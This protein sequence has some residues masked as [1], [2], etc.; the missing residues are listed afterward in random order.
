M[1][2]KT[3][4]MCINRIQNQDRGCGQYPGFLGF[5]GFLLVAALLSAA[6]LLVSVVEHVVFFFQLAVED[7]LGVLEV[8]PVEQCLKYIRN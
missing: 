6:V 7:M 4:R 5:L 1:N 3:K 2:L 8:L